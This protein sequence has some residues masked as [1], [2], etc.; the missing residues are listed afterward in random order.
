M[1]RFGNRVDLSELEATVL[2]LSFVAHCLALWDEKSHKLYLCVST[3][4]AKE[5]NDKFSNDLRADEELKTHL[6]QLPASYQPDKIKYL[7]NFRL[8]SSGK[9]CRKNLMKL[10]QETKI[11]N[12]NGNGIL[13]T[14]V[15]REIFKEIWKNRLTST[16]DDSRFLENGGNSVTAIHISNELSSALNI[17]FPELI[18]LLLNNESFAK[19]LDYVV[20]ALQSSKGEIGVEYSASNR[21]DT[22]PG[23]N[24]RMKFDPPTH[25]DEVS[26]LWQKCRGRTTGE[27][28]GSNTFKPSSKLKLNIRCTKDLKKCV[29]ASP[30]VFK[31][32]SGE[33]YASVGSHAGVISTRRLNETDSDTWEIHLP[34]RIEASVLPLNY[35]RGIVGKT[36]RD[37]H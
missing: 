15:A 26:C 7:N 25:S 8:T 17:Q 14:E 16:M 33:I 12:Q 11:Q 19:C 20:K 29:D 1:K 9:I 23:G 32:Y 34:D 22:R 21:N 31:Y 6:R 28:L 5:P 35:L 30:T 2:R 36:L 37:S 13:D 10:F 24:K 18:G 4:Y 27:I 3:N